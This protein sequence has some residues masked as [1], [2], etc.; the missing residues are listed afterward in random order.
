MPDE[1]PTWCDGLKAIVFDLQGTTADFFQPL[2]RAGTAINRD[3]GLAIDWSE[4]STEWR[5]LY[6]RTL[7]D[8]ISSYR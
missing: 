8:V 3:K 5:S 1:K 6:R 7:D 2:V 4:T